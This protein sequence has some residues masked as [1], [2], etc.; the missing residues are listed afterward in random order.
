MLEVIRTHSDTL[1]EFVRS[2]SPEYIEKSDEPSARL[3]RNAID[4]FKT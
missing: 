3:A 4:T 1:W 2:M